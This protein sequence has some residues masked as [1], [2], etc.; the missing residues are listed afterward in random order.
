MQYEIPNDM[1]FTLHITDFQPELGHIHL[2][3]DGES[4]SVGKID[5]TTFNNV[6]EATGSF[7]L[8]L[9]ITGFSQHTTTCSVN[10]LNGIHYNFDDDPDGGFDYIYLLIGFAVLIL[11]V[12]IIVIVMCCASKRKHSRQISGTSSSSSSSSRRNDDAVYLGNTQYNPYAFN[13]V[14]P[15]NVYNQPQQVP[16]PK[17]Q[18]NQP[19]DI[20]NYQSTPVTNPYA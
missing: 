4:S 5:G 18:Q 16:G 6:F 3:V 14:P 11:I 2:K 17:N 15:T 12:I 20:S 9:G 7:I 1:H 8:T 19:N 10:L 13:N